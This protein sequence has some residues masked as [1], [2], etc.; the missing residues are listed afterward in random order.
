MLTPASPK[1]STISS[2]TF[3]ATDRLI[4]ITMMGQRKFEALS[5]RARRTP[6]ELSQFRDAIRQRTH[7]QEKCLIAERCSYPLRDFAKHTR[8]MPGSARRGRS[9]FARCRRLHFAFSSI[10]ARFT[11]SSSPPAPRHDVV[12]IRRHNTDISFSRLKRCYRDAASAQHQC[13]RGEA[14]RTQGRHLVSA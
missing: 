14:A 2:A 4:D 3:A 13:R 8:Q 10:L 9:V 5:A 1:S 6:N 12:D 11:P 7:G